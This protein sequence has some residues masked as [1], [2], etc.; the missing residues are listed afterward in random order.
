MVFYYRKRHFFFQELNF[1]TCPTCSLFL[2][3][4]NVL[5]ESLSPFCKIH[6]WEAS[7]LDAEILL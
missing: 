2:L 4:S 7:T 6:F 1:R 5:I 3:K